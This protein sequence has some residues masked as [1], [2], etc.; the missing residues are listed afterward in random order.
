[1]FAFPVS[2]NGKFNC[3]KIIL[4]VTCIENYFSIYL[5]SIET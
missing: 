3:S 1:M 2:E 5:G 4:V